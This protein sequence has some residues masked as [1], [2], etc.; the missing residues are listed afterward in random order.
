MTK[1]VTTFYPEPLVGSL[2]WPEDARLGI[3]QQTLAR[4]NE[5]REKFEKF[6]QKLRNSDQQRLI[7]PG[8]HLRGQTVTAIRLV[9]LGEKP[10]LSIENGV[11]VSG[12]LESDLNASGVRVAR[13]NQGLIKRR[14]CRTILY[15][16]ELL[17]TAINNDQAFLGAHAVK[18]PHQIAIDLAAN[19]I[20][21]GIQGVFFG[22]PLEA[23]RQYEGRMAL[24]DSYHDSRR[25][26]MTRLW[27]HTS[28]HYF[29]HKILG[30]YKVKTTWNEKI[31]EAIYSQAT[32]FGPMEFS[33]REIMEMFHRYEEG[34]HCGV[35][36]HSWIDRGDSA[37]S[38]LRSK[39]ICAAL[40][41][42]GYDYSEIKEPIS[43]NDYSVLTEL[44]ERYKLI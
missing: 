31:L 39:Q 44:L 30:S 12:P 29:L 16:P 41:Y 20:G 40:N 43:D 24:S 13:P 15:D 42:C 3:T 17:Q 2:P 5:G 38:T 22:F 26:L 19:N 21:E 25:T 4:W 36:G 27:G 7:R 23:A 6:W 37:I 33:H 34:A 11:R 14:G 1:L 9:F 28:E 35:Q 10:A 18:T 8:S 32:R